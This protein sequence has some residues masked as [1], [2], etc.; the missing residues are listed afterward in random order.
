MSLVDSYI[1]Q[2]AGR[3]MQVLSTEEQRPIPRSS[4]VSRKTA[5]KQRQDLPIP[6][7]QFTKLWRVANRGRKATGL[8]MPHQLSSDPLY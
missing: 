6:K 2:V 3:H 4:H 5:L 8:G 7:R 1:A